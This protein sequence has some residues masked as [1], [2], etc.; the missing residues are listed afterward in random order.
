MQIGVG[1]VGEHRAEE[2]RELVRLCEQL[3]FDMVWFTDERFHRDAFVNMTL[4]ATVSDKLAIGCMVT[5]PFIRHPALTAA[6][7][8]TLDDLSGGRFTLGLGAGISGF[9]ELGIERIRPAKAI[10]ESIELINRL[11]SGEQGL[12]VKGDIIAFGPGQLDFL[13]ERRTPIYVAGRGPRVLQAAGALADGVVVGSYASEAGIKWALAQASRGAA[14]AGRN[15]D[16]VDKVSWLYTSVSEDRE[17]AL[18]AVRVGVAVALSGSHNILEQI[19]IELPGAVLS[20][21]ESSGYRFDR[22][23]LAKLG[24]LLPE[25]LIRR[26]SVAG[27]VEE[28]VEQ[29]TEIRELGMNQVALWPFPTSGSNLSAQLTVLGR[30]VLPALRS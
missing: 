3:G 4:A 26:L 27:T 30:N 1:L 18:D 11:T 10:R 14:R 17:A 8:A 28:V 20:H 7:S 23:A 19:G 15:L 6:A 21:M 29:L 13:P 2:T 25:E 12:H 5:D 16:A 22:P 9:R 24:A